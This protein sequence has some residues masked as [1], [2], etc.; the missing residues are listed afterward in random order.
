MTK[1]ILFMW[2]CSSIPGN[3]CKAIPTPKIMFNNHYDCVVYAYDYSLNLITGLDRKWVNKMRAHTK[4]NCK[5]EQ[6]I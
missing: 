2:L 3:Q 6:I 4:F 1:I 5:V